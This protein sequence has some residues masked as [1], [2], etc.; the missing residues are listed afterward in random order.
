MNSLITV[1]K[2]SL[3]NDYGLNGFSKKISSTKEKKRI[4]VT[5]VIM[6]FAASSIA[7]MITLYALL[8]ADALEQIG[9]LEMILVMGILVSTLTVFFTSIYKA[10]GSL[11]TSRDYDLLMSLPIKNRT[12]LTSKLINLLSLNWIFTAFI[13]VPTSIIYFIRIGNLSWLYFIMVIIGVILVPLIPVILASI[14]AI[15]IAYFASKF[16]YK[17]ITTILGSIILII[18]F[19]IGSSYMQGIMETIVANG[20]SFMG[21][22]G[23]LYPPVIYLTNTLIDTNFIELLKFIFVSVVPF[24]AFILL[25]SKSFKQI[26]SRL[27]ESYKRANY[28]MKSLKTNSLL[29]SLVNKE[30]KR[31]FSMPIYVLNT[32]IGMIM[33]IA[34]SIATL[35]IDG[36]TLAMYMDLP[37]TETLFPLVIL[38]MMIFCI[39]L[40]STTSSSISL[41]GK[42]L[43]IIKSLPIRIKDIFLGK[44]IL[45]LII[46][47]PITILANMIFFLGLKFNISNLVWNITISSVYCFVAASFGL[48]INLYFPKMEWTSP[49]SVVKQSASAMISLITTMVIIVLPVGAFILFKVNNINAF[50]AMILVLLILILIVLW[51]ILNS[52]GIKKFKQL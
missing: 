15:I 42:N 51:S 33:I 1:L 26:N 2:A 27:G 8:M 30:I 5:T 40:S 14:I 45:S 16:K 48:L 34:A 21:M 35:F 22:M 4:L 47:L 3:I 13:L 6:L 43:W 23:K 7:Y 36:E 28:S 44:I 11:F 17:N 52:K 25:F 39:G 19:T 32:A 29:Y 49:T 37:Y 50:I 24:V 31:Y 38:G 18:G 9:F 46:T 10:Q 20:T 12:I 41:E